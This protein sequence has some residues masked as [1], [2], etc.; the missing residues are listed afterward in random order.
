M[1]SERG[2]MMTYLVSHPRMS[3]F[4][5]TR[6]ACNR[7]DY[8]DLAKSDGFLP[9]HGSDS[10][11]AWCGAR[12]CQGPSLHDARESLATE[13]SKKVADLTTA[14]V[15]A[16]VSFASFE[17]TVVQIVASTL[18]IMTEQAVCSWLKHKR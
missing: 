18:S 5:C 15:M 17:R 9:N 3:Y 16:Y 10:Y 11:G 2:L 14:A 6:Y 12:G 1:I 13:P 4:A 7:V 8:G